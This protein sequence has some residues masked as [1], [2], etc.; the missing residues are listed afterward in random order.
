MD[1]ALTLFELVY[2]FKR[3]EKKERE[4]EE[5]QKDEDENVPFFHSSFAS[6]STFPLSVAIFFHPLL[7]LFQWYT[8]TH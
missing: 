5:D 3:I 7:K 4:D 8:I 6:F 2:L 1:I